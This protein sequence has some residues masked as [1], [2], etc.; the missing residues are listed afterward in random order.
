MECTSLETLDLHANSIH[1]LPKH[2][3]RLKNLKK[4]AIDR[5]H[6]THM[7]TCIAHMGSLHWIDTRNNPIEFPDK[8]LWKLSGRYSDE[9]TRNPNWDRLPEETKRLKRA[10]LQHAKAERSPESELR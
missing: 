6:V 5:N 3:S 7:P 10:L 2:L 8:Q 9:G 4:F 1:S